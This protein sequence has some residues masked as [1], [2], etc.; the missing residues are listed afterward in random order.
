MSTKSHHL[1]METGESALRP[2]VSCPMF[3][4]GL[5]NGQ[6]MSGAVRWLD[7]IPA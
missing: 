6:S 1:L 2:P 3:A 7:S 5:F 4:N